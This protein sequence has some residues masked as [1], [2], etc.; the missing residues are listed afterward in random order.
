MTTLE[1]DREDVSALTDLTSVA[2]DPFADFLSGPPPVLTLEPDGGEA[3]S[4]ETFHRDVAS[5]AMEVLSHSGRARFEE[6]RSRAERVERLVLAHLDALRAAGTLPVVAEYFQS[7]S[8]R[9]PW[10]VWASVLA[11]A[12]LATVESHTA[13]VR[14][15]ESCDPED[16]TTA[17]LAAEA[18]ALVRRPDDGRIEEALAASSHPVA[19]AVALDVRS[20]RGDAPVDALTAALAS[21]HR[22]LVE[23]ALRALDTLSGSPGALIDPVF[24]LLEAPHPTTAWRAARF[25]TL[26]G[27]TRPYHAVRDGA[28]LAARLG[29]TGLELL[30]M[31]GGAGDL[32]LIDARVSR[33]PVSRD[34]LSVVGRLGHPR[35]WSFLA[36]F[37]ADEM[38]GEAAESA[39]VTLL[40]PA[41][42]AP[43]RRRAGAWRSALSTLRPDPAV[44]LRR[45]EPWRPGVVAAEITSGALGRVAISARIDEIAARTGARSRVD[46]GAWS[47]GVEPALAEVVA[48]AGAADR[49][50]TPGAWGC[51]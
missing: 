16:A 19:R 7:A 50:W 17:I 35:A 21:P 43:E 41:V 37:L 36:H 14:G 51:D 23:V 4:L 46:L 20:R 42:P 10:P 1:D 18:L 13:L 31:R 9:N 28:P 34:L 38:L 15:I 5:D 24:Q 49:R 29:A 30:V 48:A 32:A 25:L 12:S 40:G 8:P 26:A 33:M 39:L 45:G 22:P 44:R 27:D 3:I 11:L 47:A 2:N 6:P